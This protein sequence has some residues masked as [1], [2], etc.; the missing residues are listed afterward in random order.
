MYDI[1]IIG[2]GPA[3]LTA[4]TYS[5]RAGKT[6]LIIEKAGFGGQVA[7][8]PKIENFP[9]TASVSGSELAEK[10]VEQALSLGAETAFGE[11]TA[12]KTR[13]GEFTVCTDDGDYDCKA[14][15]IASGAK[16]RR[17]NV[18]GE[19]EFAGNGVSYCAVCDGAFF[20]GHKVAIVGGGNSALQEAILLS[21]ICTHVT[22]IQNLP[23]LT[24]EAKLQEIVK[25]REN[26][27]VIYSVTVDSVVGSETLE[28]AV[29]RHADSGETEKI[30]C[31]GLFVAIGLEPQNKA[32]E[33]VV[34]L[35]EYGYI[36]ADE[37]CVT[38]TPGI[39]AAGDCRT[40]SVRQITTAVGDGAVAS[41]N[42]CKYIN[43]H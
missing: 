14:V 39:Y 34:T 9:G 27:D 3:G 18:P 15:I 1:V 24:G 28:G 10:L 12:I 6:V 33:N 11:V 21:D 4:A 8:S 32:F 43:Q 2:A 22:V 37:S 5:L 36:I 25:E 35:N 40:K 17:L 26:I 31:D 13:N 7:F 19:D 30:T 16:H 41:V 23:F 38:G 29:I 42:A 20:A